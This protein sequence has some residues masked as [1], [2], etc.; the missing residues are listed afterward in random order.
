MHLEQKQP[1]PAGFGT[2]GIDPELGL[3]ATLPE[4]VGMPVAKP[5]QPHC[6][7]SQYA[8]VF[9]PPLVEHLRAFR[10][11]FVEGAGVSARE[12]RLFHG[13]IVELLIRCM[14]AEGGAVKAVQLGVVDPLLDHVIG[15]FCRAC[16]A[17]ECLKLALR[18]PAGHAALW[19]NDMF[20]NQAELVRGGFHDHPAGLGMQFLQAQDGSAR[21]IIA[22]LGTM[23]YAAARMLSYPEGLA[24]ARR[25]LEKSEAVA[26]KFSQSKWSNSEEVRALPCCCWEAVRA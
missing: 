3:T 22:M 9:I 6:C 4:S 24:E 11:P 2:P 25:L 5:D 21:M 10:A 8:H 20:P 13:V 16:P 17:M 1:S 23:S 15:P 26:D 12:N 7:T 19:E 14:Q 18:H